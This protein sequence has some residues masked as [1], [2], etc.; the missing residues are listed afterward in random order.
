[1][2]RRTASAALVRRPCDAPPLRS[3]I[4]SPGMKIGL[5]GGSFDPPH[6]G[7]LHVARVARD[8][9]G[10]DRVWWLVAPQNPLKDR[11]AAAA[12]QDRLAQV[13]A[14]ATDPGFVVSDL[15]GRL[16]TPYTVDVV[17]TLRRMRPRVRFVFVM[18]ADS[19]QSLH[20]WRDWPEILRALPIAVV[21]RP[22][23]AVRAQL[24]RA[25]Q[26]FR[27]AR[28]DPVNAPALLETG[29]PAWLYISA[30][31]HPA[32]ST[33]LRKAARGTQAIPPSPNPSS[34]ATSP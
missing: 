20:R 1:M 26:R 14:L 22:G 18:G 17:T 3:E 4:L 15:Q 30:R 2:P 33:A 12:Y 24:S 8:R 28:V 16:G 21:A 23:D 29:P 6:E 25:A 9:L 32:S 7:H 27:D 19:L 31:M 11:G 13:R 34:Q 10:L 5:F